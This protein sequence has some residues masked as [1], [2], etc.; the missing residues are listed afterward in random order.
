MLTSP[1]NNLHSNLLRSRAGQ[2]TILGCTPKDT[3]ITLNTCIRRGRYCHDP[4]MCS[5]LYCAIINRIPSAALRP[6]VRGYASDAHYPINF[7][8]KDPAFS[9]IEKAAL[10]R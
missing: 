1:E 4:T 9:T 5:A 2:I 7:V 10:R 8:V 6:L 3:L